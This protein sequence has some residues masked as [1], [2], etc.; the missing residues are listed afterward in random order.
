[1]FELFAGTEMRSAIKGGSMIV[2]N[3]LQEYFLGEIER[4]V[5]GIAG[6]LSSPGAQRT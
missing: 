3:L 5:P 2:I 4:I 6:G 1:M